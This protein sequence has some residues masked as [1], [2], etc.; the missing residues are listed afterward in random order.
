MEREDG[1]EGGEG[2]KNTEEEGF[3]IQITK[4]VWEKKGI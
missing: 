2:W 1:M 3:E 4:S